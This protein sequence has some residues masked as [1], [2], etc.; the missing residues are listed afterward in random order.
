MSF[1]ISFYT[2]SFYYNN[3][4]HGVTELDGRA[5]VAASQTWARMRAPNNTFA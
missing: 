1:I 4:K 2:Q 5:L 3:R